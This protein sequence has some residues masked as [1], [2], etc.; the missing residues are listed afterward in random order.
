MKCSRVLSD[1]Q[2]E[3]TDCNLTAPSCESAVPHFQL[4]GTNRGL[5]FSSDYYFEY[6]SNILTY[7]RNL[8]AFSNPAHG[9]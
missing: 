5:R 6:G 7:A 8:V 2:P 3:V 9:F 4:G 1:R